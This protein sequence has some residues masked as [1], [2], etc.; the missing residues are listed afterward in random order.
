MTFDPLAFARAEARQ[1][2]N[3]LR[4]FVPGVDFEAI[5]AANLR[6]YNGRTD[7]NRQAKELR[8]RAAGIVVPA[9]VPEFFVDEAALLASEGPTRETTW[10]LTIEPTTPGAPC[11]PSRSP[12]TAG[13]TAAVPEPSGTRRER[14][15]PRRRPGRPAPAQRRPPAAPAGAQ[16]SC[17]AC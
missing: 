3:A 11:R 12:W 13:T 6:D 5:E 7:L 9:G 2:Y 10:V 14:A 15:C 4:K 8:T 16:G 1:Q 17:P